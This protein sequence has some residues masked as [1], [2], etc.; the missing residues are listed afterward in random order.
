MHSAD[1]LLSESDL[2]EIRR[3]EESLWLAQSRFDNEL[4]DQTF[5]ADFFE[6]G[7][8]GRRYLRAEMMFEPGTFD[9]IK[10]TLPLPHFHARYLSDDI[11]QVTYVSEVIYDGEKELANRSSIWAR[12]GDGWQLRFH[13]GTPV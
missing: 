9:E 5:A 1:Q 11:V 8:S 13:Q 10:A 2:A 4:M 3:L 7:R 12:A 6:F